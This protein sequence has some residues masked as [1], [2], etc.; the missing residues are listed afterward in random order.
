MAVATRRQRKIP[1]EKLQENHLSGPA[2]ATLDEIAD[3]LGVDQVVIAAEIPRL[4]K[5][6]FR[7][8]RDP[9]HVLEF[10]YA[11]KTHPFKMYKLIDGQQ[12]DLP[13]EVIRNLEQCRENIEKY[14]RN[15]EGIPEVY[16]AGYK[17]HFVCERAA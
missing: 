10:H 2:D 13:W 8:Q 7:N 15:K 9:G 16:V 14:R 5:I 17:T 1:V 6:T 11:S 3:E 4:E 12:Y